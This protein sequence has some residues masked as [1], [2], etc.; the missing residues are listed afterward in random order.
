M[1]KKLAV[2][3]IILLVIG[4]TGAIFTFKSYFFVQ[5]QEEYRQIEANDIEHIQINSNVANM[6]ILPS[7]SQKVEVSWSNPNKKR[8]QL[9][10][11]ISEKN[12]T[13]DIQAKLKHRFRFLQLGP[14]TIDVDIKLPN[15]VFQSLEAK[16]NVGAIKIEDIAADDMIVSND[17]GSI[18]LKD[19][20]GKQLQVKNNVGAIKI[21]NIATEDITVSN[22]TG[23]TVLKDIAG[24]Q[25]QVKTKIGKID[26]TDTVGKLQASSDTGAISISTKKIEHDMHLETE[27]GSITIAVPTIPSDVSF[28]LHS[29]IGSV[30]AFGAKGS[31]IVPNAQTVVKATSSVGSIQVKEK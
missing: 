31:H 3:A 17:T 11:K 5:K 21:E 25:L 13:L 9:D 12:G 27:I 15:K 26:L 29:E 19:I 18:G 20:T 30:K 23:K 22:D 16:N 10:V 2:A 14:S 6:H 4:I 8:N 28:D 24:K 7:N 1:V